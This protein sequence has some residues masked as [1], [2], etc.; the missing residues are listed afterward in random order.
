[1][2]NL[3]NLPTRATLETTRFSVHDTKY[4]AAG[5]MHRVAWALQ[6]A[7]AIGQKFEKPWENLWFC[8]GQD[9]I[10]TFVGF[11]CVFL[12][13]EKDRTD[14]FGNNHTITDRGEHVDFASLQQII[15]PKALIQY[16]HSPFRHQFHA[17]LYLMMELQVLASA[18]ALLFG[19]T[20]FGSDAVP[21]RCDG[22]RYP[23]GLQ[24]DVESHEFPG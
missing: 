10:R 2:Q 15:L 17:S 12:K 5:A 22:H 16:W 24:A 20:P 7:K 11:T 4:N 21:H 8:S 9:R 19:L 1:M 14:A 23:A 13:F 3:S 6:N 18:V